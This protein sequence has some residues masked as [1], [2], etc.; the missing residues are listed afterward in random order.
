ML[1]ISLPHNISLQ[2]FVR[3]P[4]TLC[5]NEKKILPA[6]SHTSPGTSTQRISAGLCAFAGDVVLND[7]VAA[8]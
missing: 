5:E 7:A 3:W 8:K 4:G 6:Y 2:A 1:D